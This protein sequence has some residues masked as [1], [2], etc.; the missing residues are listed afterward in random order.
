MIFSAKSNSKLI[1]TFFHIF[2]R[3][4]L[5]WSHHNKNSWFCKI[6]FL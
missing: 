4:S 6:K 1:E 5:S 2:G 3:A